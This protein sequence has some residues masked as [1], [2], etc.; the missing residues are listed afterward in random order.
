M[1]EH[2]LWFTV[3][4][5]LGI[6]LGLW[7]ALVGISGSLLV[8]EEPIDAWLNPE[9]L[10][11]PSRG[12]WLPPETIVEVARSSPGLA[13]VERVRLP[14]AAGEVYRLQLRAAPSRGGRQERV[15]ATFDP[16]T[17]K[18]LGMRGTETLGVDRRHL[19][20]SV[21]EFHRNVLLGTVGS[22]I[23][24]IAGFALLASVVTGLVLAIPKKR[25]GWA[26]V[27][28]VNLR[29]SATRVFFDVHRS[30]GSVFL[31]LLLLTTIT[32]ATL[33]YLNYVR[34]LVSVFSKVATFPT[35]PWVPGSRED[36]APFKHVVDT[37][38]NDFPDRTITEIHLPLKATAGYLFYLHRAG[39]EYR[40]GDTIVWAH[41]VT[42]ELLVE[43]SD[44]TR[45]AGETLMHW[46]FPLHSG[47]AFGTPGMIAMCLTGLTPLLLVA[48]GLWVWLRKRRGERIGEKRRER[49]RATGAA[50][51]AA[52][53]VL[54]STARS[55]AR[56]QR[57]PTSVGNSDVHSA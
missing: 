31:V 44:R 25:S 19:L 17:G 1:R 47:T 7:F 39:D 23:V 15:E 21:Y 28:W 27:V 52:P 54:T 42:G 30:V 3:H 43:R 18:L 16:V 55:S 29:A 8:F 14:M 5:W 20:K 56:R 53:S 36:V 22:N 51:P 11:T 40:L 24:G 6:A 32:G 38:R 37:V 10:S 9:L 57:S 2:K 26:R 4:K 48:T 13:G 50:V 12:A 33:V 34:D 41:P 49:R 46:L 35:I 45:N